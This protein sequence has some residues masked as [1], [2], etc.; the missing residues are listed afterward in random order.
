MPLYDIA[1]FYA[2]IAADWTVIT[3]FFSQS[4]GRGEVS[5]NIRLI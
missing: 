2:A 4:T 3:P 5:L 1:G